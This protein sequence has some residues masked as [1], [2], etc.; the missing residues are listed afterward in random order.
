MTLSKQEKANLINYKIER[1]RE[2]A[3]EARLMIHNSKF[4]SAVNRIYYTNFYAVSA[5][6]LTHDFST[7]KHKQLI[8][9]FNKT[10]V[11]TGIVDPR[12]GG[13]LSR[14]FENRT[15]GDY[16]DFIQFTKEEVEKM[17]GDMNEFI[18]EIEKLLKA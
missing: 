7:S 2:T 12:F 18:N 1:A 5:L 4:F 11:K 10:F 17:F 8:G 16:G 6:A 15:E 13:I 14:S 9:W 3:E